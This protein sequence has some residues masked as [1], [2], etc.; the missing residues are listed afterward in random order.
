MRLLALLL[1]CLAAVSCGKKGDLMP[2]P[3]YEAPAK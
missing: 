2:P 3:G 1:L